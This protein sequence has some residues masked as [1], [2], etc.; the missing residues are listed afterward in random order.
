V[1]KHIERFSAKTMTKQAPALSIVSDTGK[2]H[3]GRAVRTFEGD[4]SHCEVLIDGGL[5]GGYLSYSILT[6]FREID[7][8]TFQ[9]TA[10]ICWSVIR[11]TNNTLTNLQQ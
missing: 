1:L 10:L 7:K 9:N 11:Q 3:N 2:K 5:T 6:D 8:T 4:E